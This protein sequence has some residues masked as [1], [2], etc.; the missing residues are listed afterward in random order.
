MYYGFCCFNF[1]LF[2]GVTEF[3]PKLQHAEVIWMKPT[4]SSEKLI[5]KRPG[6]SKYTLHTSL[7][8][9]IILC[10]TTDI[11]FFDDEGIKRESKYEI[12]IQMSSYKTD[13]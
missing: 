13:I 3:V 4:N 11:N 1:L 8:F 6:L 2:P 9:E 10:L 5:T 7:I 12:S